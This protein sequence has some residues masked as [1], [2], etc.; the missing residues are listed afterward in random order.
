TAVTRARRMVVIV[1]N[2]N[3][4]NDMIDNTLE[5]KRYTGFTR[6]ICELTEQDEKQEYMM[7]FAEDEQEVP[8]D[9]FD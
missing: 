4:I 7:L 1:G 8:D 3:K 2:L 5:Q 6:R 9:L